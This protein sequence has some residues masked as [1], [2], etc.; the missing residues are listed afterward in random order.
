MVAQ[1]YH[2]SYFYEKHYMILHSISDRH[3]FYGTAPA[4]QRQVGFTTLGNETD[5][6]LHCRGQMNSAMSLIQEIA[7]QDQ[8]EPGGNSRARHHAGSAMDS[9]KRIKTF[10]DV[11][12]KRSFLVP[13]IM[14]IIDA[15]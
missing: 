13:P 10:L 3:A 8:H 6:H 7:C 11:E 14:T 2:D 4:M 12:L 5:A 15:Y 1:S 9:R